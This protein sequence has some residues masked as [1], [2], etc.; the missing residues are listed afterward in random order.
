MG[1]FVFKG[2]LQEKGWIENAV[3]KTNDFGVITSIKSDPE[4]KDG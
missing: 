3:I 2:L 1:E 4:R